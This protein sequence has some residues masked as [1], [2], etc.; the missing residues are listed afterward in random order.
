M[1]SQIKISVFLIT[2]LPIKYVHVVGECIGHVCIPDSYDK[3][4]L[5]LQ[6][7]INHVKVDYKGIRI[8]KVD[9]E[10]FTITLSFL[11]YL[12]WID[13]RLNVKSH[14]EDMSYRNTTFTPLNSKIM[15]KI[16]VP[17]PQIFDVKN[18]KSNPD[19][20]FLMDQKYIVQIVSIKSITI[21]CSMEFDNY[22][23][24]SHICYLKVCSTSYLDDKVSYNTEPFMD[25]YKLDL[26]GHHFKQLTVLDYEVELNKLPEKH[27]VIE[28]GSQKDILRGSIAGFEIKLYRKYEKYII[29]YYV[30]SGLI[31]IISCVSI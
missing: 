20:I 26:T 6:N 23:L 2:I 29:Y 14:S 3:A 7:E 1:N 25:D 8:L 16:W 4:I 15:D 11:L 10:E 9:D 12:H 5:P 28:M 24:D 31:A 21:Y 22:P 27:S 17:I 30:P 18:I 19:A 13:S